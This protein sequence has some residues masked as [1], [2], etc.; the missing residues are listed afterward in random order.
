M[1]DV[2]DLRSD[3]VTKPTAGMRAAMAAAV[4]GDDVLGDDPTVIE[5]EA[6]SAD[7]MGKEAALFVPSGTMGNLIALCVHTRPGDEVLLDWDAHSIR[8]EAGGAGAIAGVVT[9]QFRSVR[10]VPDL[11][12]LVAALQPESLH[13][14]A[15]RLVMLENTHNVAGGAVVPLAISQ[16]VHTACSEAGVAVHLDGARLFNAAASSGVGVRAYADQADT[17]TFCLSKGLGCPVGS[18]LCGSR[19]MME[20]ARRLR[21]RLGAGMRQSGVLAA[22]GLYALDRHVAR[23]PEDHVRAARLGQAVAGLRGA[24]ADIGS[25]QTNMVYFT[26]TAPASRWVDALAEYG[27][28][29][30]ALAPNRVRLVTHLD[31]DDAGIE[32]AIG[33]MGEVDRNLGAA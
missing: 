28:R 6:R 20:Q 19:D 29:C 13:T 1:A 30:L 25:V 10:G 5:L 17:V 11:E 7:L 33:A 23:L 24:A 2:V 22:A 8:F 32:R 15:T 14:P 26:T 9:R 31:V 21:K 27:V 12:G 4:V 3:T 16:A 18:V